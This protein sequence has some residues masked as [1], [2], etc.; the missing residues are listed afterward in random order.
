M[1]ALPSMLSFTERSHCNLQRDYPLQFGRGVS[2]MLPQ[3]GVQ[4]DHDLR[5]A[6]GQLTD[7]TLQRFLKPCLANIE[8]QDRRYKGLQQ[9]P[10][11]SY[12]TGSRPFFSFSVFF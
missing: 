2:G 10:Q 8:L 4:K 7:Q 3:H 1:D 12:R 11:W 5:I 6:N 9:R